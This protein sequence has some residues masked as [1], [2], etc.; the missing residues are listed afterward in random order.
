M[1]TAISV[2]STTMAYKR[3]ALIPPIQRSPLSRARLVQQPAAPA[4]GEKLQITSRVR[5]VWWVDG[6]PVVAGENGSPRQLAQPSTTPRGR[7]QIAASTDYL[8]WEGVG[9]YLR[10]A[11]GAAPA[12]SGGGGSGESDV[13]P[14]DRSSQ[15]GSAEDGHGGDSDLVPPDHANQNGAAFHYDEGDFYNAHRDDGVQETTADGKHVDGEGSQNATKIDKDGDDETDSEEDDEDIDEDEDDEMTKKRK[16]SQKIV[17]S[18]GHIYA[19]CHQRD[20]GYAFYRSLYGIYGL[21]SDR[22]RRQLAAPICLRLGVLELCQRICR[23]SVKHH[24]VLKS[25]SGLALVIVKSL[26]SHIDG[27]QYATEA[28]SRVVE[29]GFTEQFVDFLRADDLNP[30][31]VNS[32]TAEQ[33][34]VARTVLETLCNVLQAENKTQASST[35]IIRDNREQLLELL[36][37]YRSGSDCVL[38]CLALTLQVHIMTNVGALDEKALDL[39]SADLPPVNHDEMQ[40]EEAAEILETLKKVIA[41]AKDTTRRK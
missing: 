26:T 28:S 33:R 23:R 16:T 18:L 5:P 12:D 13:I 36:Q 2:S 8:S 32:F 3:Y 11:S 29:I 38:S 24:E 27:E 21:V 17:R 41:R 7:K 31:R 14:S 20:F 35:Q 40:S 30:E 39:L 1:S 15:G 22:R 25:T 9:N 10:N 37:K 6:H 19:C 34:E 4:A